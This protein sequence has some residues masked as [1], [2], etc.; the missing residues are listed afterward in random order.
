MSEKKIEQK[1]WEKS[2]KITVT[3]VANASTGVKTESTAST[4]KAAEKA[5]AKP[6]SQVENKRIEINTDDKKIG[7]KIDDKKTGAG[8]ENKKTETK[9]EMKKADTKTDVKKTDSKTEVKV[10][11][12]RKF[13]P[14]I[15]KENKTKSKEARENQK[16]LGAKRNIP[17]FR[18]RFGKKNIRRK[19][20]AKWDKWRKPH[21]IDLDKGLQHGFRP[22]IGYGNEK[23]IRFIH[24]SGYREVLVCNMNDIVKLNPK[25]EAA[26][27]S[28]TLGK[29]KRNEIM[30]KANEKGIWVLN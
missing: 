18:G 3:K 12:K 9:T 7:T 15:K 19:S 23:E 26:R 29:R 11:K 24:P 22:K 17:T 2:G 4:S 20:I 27:F 5:T 6:I 8:T 14:Y 28:A 21:G 30:K 16:K 13:I 1:A 25:T 10:E